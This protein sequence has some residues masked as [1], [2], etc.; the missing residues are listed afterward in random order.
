[1]TL[2]GVERFN[3]MSDVSG[4]KM[5]PVILHTHTHTQTHTHTHPHTHTHTHTHKHHTTTTHT[6]QHPHTHTHTHTHTQT[7]SVVKW[8][9]N[10]IETQN[11]I[12]CCHGTSCSSHVR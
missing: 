4:R 10:H 6:H 7:H 11:N 1:M 5:L 2:Q 12:L 9:S 3:H 8:G